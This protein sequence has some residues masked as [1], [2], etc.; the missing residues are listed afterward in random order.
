MDD[1]RVTIPITI[2]AKVEN[3]FASISKSFQKVTEDITKMSS[4]IGQSFRNV[5]KQMSSSFETANAGIIGNLHKGFNELQSSL[6]QTSRETETTVRAIE[7][8]LKSLSEMKIKKTTLDIDISGLKEAKKILDDLD[9]AA[10]KTAKKAAEK[11]GVVYREEDVKVPKDLKKKRLDAGNIPEEYRTN[12]SERL[13]KAEAA[14]AVLAKKTEEM[15]IRTYAN[16]GK[17]AE[18]S[19]KD[20]SK[21]AT[22]QSEIITTLANKSVE[23]LKSIKNVSGNLSEDV[24]NALSGKKI[25]DQA[26]VQEQNLAKSLQVLEKQKTEAIRAEQL[27]RLAYEKQT[28]DAAKAINEQQWRNT[29]THLNDIIAKYNEAAAAQGKLSQTRVDREKRYE[30]S[31][32]AIREN[33]LKQIA[34]VNLE[35]VFNKLNTDFQKVLSS[36]NAF[37]EG[38][39]AA[40]Q[41]IGEGIKASIS[42]ID[43][44]KNSLIAIKNELTTLSKSRPK[45]TALKQDLQSV[46]DLITELGKYRKEYLAAAE[47]S[48]KM[49]LTGP[50]FKSEQ[51]FANISKQTEVFRKNVFDAT[52]KGTTKLQTGGDNAFSILEAHSA[53]KEAEKNIK[54]YEKT[55]EKV[56]K[57][58]LALKLES[59]KIEVEKTK[60]TNAIKIKALENY[61][62]AVQNQ[63]KVLQEQTSILKKTIP[64]A[65]I[66][67]SGVL[68]SG[69]K[70]LD[71]IKSM[72]TA[73]G[74]GLWKELK[75]TMQGIEKE[76]DNIIYQSKRYKQENIDSAQKSKAAFIDLQGTFEQN[77]QKIITMIND[78]KNLTKKGIIDATPEI[79]NL[80]KLRAEYTKVSQSVRQ[81]AAGMAKMMRAQEQ[82]AAKSPLTRFWEY[83]RDLRWQIAAVYYMATRAVQAVKR[84]FLDS[85][86]EVSEFRASVF[87]LAASIGLSMG[88]SFSIGFDYFYNFS[89]DLMDK[90]QH[91]A[92]TT[93]ATM[94]DLMMVTKTFAQAGVF[95]RDDKDVERI[96][97]IASSVKLLTEGMSN[98]GTQMRQE[99][100]A[101]LRGTQRATDQVA[102]AFLLMGIDIKKQMIIWK[103]EGK[104]VIEGIAESLDAVRT[105]NEKISNEYKAQVN[106]L[107]AIWS[108]IK[109]IALQDTTLTIAQDIK[110]F[111]ATLG[112]PG[113]GLTDL[114]KNIALGIKSSFEIIWELTKQIGA[115]I[116]SIIQTINALGSAT[117]LIFE[118]FI[119]TVNFIGSGF[120]F[121]GTPIR[122]A[123]DELIGMAQITEGL[124]KT[125]LVISAAFKFWLAPIYTSIKWI[126]SALEMLRAFKH[127]TRAAW[128]SEFGSTKEA[129]EEFKKADEYL[130]KAKKAFLDP[131]EKFDYV[132][133][134]KDGFKSAEKSAEK[135]HNLFKNMDFDK[136]FVD[137]I[138]ASA[139]VGKGLIDT[140]TELNNMRKESL[141]KEEKGEDRVKEFK[142]RLETQM[143][144][145]NEMLNKLKVK[146]IEVDVKIVNE[147]SNTHQNINKDIFETTK[148]SINQIV[149]LGTTAENVLL[150]LQDTAKQT[151]LPGPRIVNLPDSN[152]KENKRK[153]EMLEIQIK[154]LEDFQAKFSNADDI[155]NK[156]LAKMN[157]KEKGKTTEE[158]YDQYMDLY[159]K[160]GSLTPFDKV[161]R[162]YK[163]HLREIAKLAEENKYVAQNRA[164]FELAA[165]AWKNR[166]MLDA[167]REYL[168]TYEDLKREMLGTELSEIEKLVKEYEN[169]DRKIEKAF[170]WDTPAKLHLQGLTATG[171]EIKK[172]KLETER[173]YEISGKQ[174]DN[175]SKQAD[176][177]EKSV[178]PYDKQVASINKLIIAHEQMRLGIE[179]E[180]DE[181]KKLWGV[182]DANFKQYKS[183]LE[184]QL[185][186][187]KEFTESEIKDVQEP[188]WKRMKEM[189]EGFTEGFSTA[190]NDALW[191]FKNFSKTL[192]DFFTNTLKQFTQAFIQFNV[193]E[194]LMKQLSSAGNQKGGFQGVAG[195]AYNPLTWI[196]KL[197]GVLGGFGG[198]KES[199]LSGISMINPL[200]VKVV[201]DIFTDFGKG[202]GGGNTFGNIGTGVTDLFSGFKDLFSLPTYHS[203]GKISGKYQNIPGIEKNEVLALLEEGELVLTEKQ[204]KNLPK[205]HDGGLVGNYL[206]QGPDESFLEAQERGA[207][208]L[209]QAFNKGIDYFVGRFSK[210][211]NDP[212]AMMKD[213]ADSIENSFGILS[214]SHLYGEEGT[215]KLLDT[216]M[217]FGPGMIG[218]TFLGNKAKGFEAAK[219][220]GKT[221][222]FGGLEMF[223]LPSMESMVNRKEIDKA[224]ESF[225]N[226]A[227]TYVTKLGEL[228]ENPNLYENISELKD[229]KA[230]ISNALTD[231]AFFSRKDKEF[232]FDIGSLIDDFSSAYY[233]KKEA[234]AHETQHGVNYLQGWPSGGS[235]LG[236]GIQL[237]IDY[238]N[239][240]EYINSYKKAIN[241]VDFMKEN[242]IV[243]PL[244]GATKYTAKTGEKVEQ[245][246][247][248]SLSAFTD[249]LRENKLTFLQQ[250]SEV[251][252]ERYNEEVVP[253]VM[254]S[255]VT[256]KEGL[257]NAIS[258]MEKDIETLSVI[259]GTG[260]INAP[261]F[262]DPEDIYRG[263][264][265]E[266]MANEAGARTMYEKGKPVYMTKPPFEGINPDDYLK[267]NPDV[268]GPWY[269]PI[270]PTFKYREVLEK[271]LQ[272][273]SGK[274][275]GLGIGGAGIM[276][277]GL[278]GGTAEAK[279]NL[280]ALNKPL[281]NVTENLEKLETSS[282]Q[283][284]T[285]FMSSASSLISGIGSLFGA[286]GQQI[287]N[288]A[289]Q[290]LQFG[291]M[292]AKSY[293][294]AEGGIINEPVFG[295]GLK[296]GSNYTFGE[297]ESELVTPMSKMNNFGNGGETTN[298]NMS[299]SIN[300]VDTQ[301]GMEFLMKNSD[302]L[303]AQMV[304]AIKNN[305]SIRSSVKRS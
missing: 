217:N 279:E 221:F 212:D 131:F 255:L 140:Y 220:A 179:K 5:A 82:Q 202:F 285:S 116:I 262:K 210:A 224:I 237:P 85:L 103:S 51:H 101:L 117:Y 33:A 230:T 243:T 294:Y 297:K 153:K 264:F 110:K 269:D 281:E 197:S 80:E 286:K 185:R 207:E 278:Y 152:L 192:Q 93:Y 111:V 41:R 7:R 282:K 201:N 227:D 74:S 289:G 52:T 268:G 11:A 275:F 182:N 71:N 173:Y 1:D 94:E 272:S 114:G 183:I 58:I 22:K 292:A 104:S 139:G 303:Q 249:Y 228:W 187:D 295:V 300:A 159:D 16:V 91:K 188:F 6:K 87:G 214:K 208:K 81:D 8:S 170:Y 141:T 9:K 211:W 133:D 24:K 47:M 65:N 123:K 302:F 100:Y 4:G 305:K 165:E 69:R 247:V 13:G 36:A 231:S 122:E 138:N 246:D 97:T 50:V 147:L 44:F 136:S 200:P 57:D 124:L 26:L 120:G 145:S 48:R 205:F 265:G 149:N 56:E 129:L 35:S 151:S 213:M 146:L 175:Y 34:P 115:S 126:E 39:K 130:E 128:L 10:K 194:P 96:S 127:A 49:V 154:A 267:T 287:G 168:D 257:K 245:R 19:I 169:L 248:V 99:I 89:S 219:K 259:K 95:I 162:Q 109:R 273:F 67:G 46:K 42:N 242:Q 38:G 23:A 112:S 32:S 55:V 293:G 191:D 163:D 226:G 143:K 118:A 263:L 239:T 232:G 54:L 271:E 60:E 270:S 166:E 222:E 301:T 209:T 218:S 234:L 299:L 251:S 206:S 288:F 3:E 43:T 70:F 30:N 190:L 37:G 77:R 196:S 105:M 276:G 86:N 132:K 45:D 236:A 59:Q 18:S 161:E 144:I 193:V 184:E 298:V 229:Y 160:L 68:A 102:M 178:N 164:E 108:Y 61:G 284:S 63:I 274:S 225:R 167:T 106:N 240:L 142:D 223:E 241:V 291:T 189:A 113:E 233:T 135:I 150:D 254:D 78:L 252:I 171:F 75:S 98:A 261:G 17:L 238:Q 204:L 90:L 2:S 28:N 40:I 134:L 177:L 66:L 27:A 137:L 107:N 158:L 53:Y 84:L 250:S 256:F 266:M 283:L 198:E 72:G 92:A 304:K 181:K 79:A 235:A 203:G 76:Y 215:G 290:V 195:G 253:K 277:A 83:F 176:I 180:I 121:W 14:R 280:E 156:Y 25:L 258:Y 20:I 199:P 21:S 174:L 148:N 296:S 73:E 31:I 155:T 172:L 186:L 119:E 157:K 15:Q 62:A 88:K 125:I 64:D 216:A 12:V 260:N 244:E 29:L